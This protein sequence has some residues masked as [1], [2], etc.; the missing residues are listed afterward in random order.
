MKNDIVS[1]SRSWWTL[2]KC[3]RQRYSDS[4]C[5]HERVYTNQMDY[6]NQILIGLSKVAA[7]ETMCKQLMKTNDVYI[8]YIKVGSPYRSVNQRNFYSL[9]SFLLVNVQHVSHSSFVFEICVFYFS[10]FF[11]WTGQKLIQRERIKRSKTNDYNNPTGCQNVIDLPRHSIAKWKRNHDNESVRNRTPTPFP[12]HHKLWL[13]WNAWP[14][15]FSKNDGNAT[16]QPR[17]RCSL[18]I[19]IHQILTQHKYPAFKEGIKPGWL[20]N[21]VLV[22]GTRR[23]K[24]H[25]HKS[26]WNFEFALNNRPRFSF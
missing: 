4:R 25:D 11:F 6:T 1:V 12:H 21:I 7:W 15:L 3:P 19:W 17:R 13:F 2:S 14:Q 22:D 24:N 9:L 5:T 8:M 18:L 10:Y 26:A 16:K 23:R 20:C